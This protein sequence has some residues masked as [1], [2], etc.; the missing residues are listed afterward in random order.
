MSSNLMGIGVSG[1]HA[2]QK[3]LDTTGNNIVNANTEG[4]SRQRTELKTQ[5]PNFQGGNYIG[6]GVTIS[7]I[8]RMHD[9]LATDL[10]REHQ[11]TKSG[12]ESYVALADQVDD[13]L[14]DQ[15]VSLGHSLE[16]YFNKWQNVASDP[17]NLPARQLLITQSKI[18]TEQ[19]HRVFSQ[20]AT[21]DTSINTQMARQVDIVN[22][23]TK[24]IADLNQEISNAK[25]GNTGSLPNDLLD[26]RDS[27]INELA[28]IITVRTLNTD[29]GMTVA[30]GTG[31]SLVVG[32]KNF[33]LETA[34]LPDSENRLGIYL[35]V[36]E[37]S[38]LMNQNVI[39]SYLQ[40][41]TQFREEILTPSINAIGR[42]AVG[43]SEYT[44]QQHQL[45][46]DLNGG[47]GKLF[48][49]NLSTS[50]AYA[51][52]TNY[53]DAQITSQITDISLLPQSDY[54]FEFNGE[55]YLVTRM[56]DQAE[57]GSFPPGTITLAN[58]GLSIT[59]SGSAVSGD[60][61][62][63]Q[64]TRFGARDLKLMP[65]N[66]NDIAA[67]QPVITQR[68][69]Q[70]TGTATIQL[71]EVNNVS[72]G[73]FTTQAGALTP[74]LLIRFTSNSNYDIYDN[75]TPS[76]PVLL[77][78]GNAFIPD[79]LNLMIPGSLNYG[80]QVS[81]EGAPETNDLFYVDYNTGGSTD[82]RNAISI[83]NLQNIRLLNNH[84]AT[85]NSAYGKIVSDV[86]NNTH[87]AHLS[88]EASDSLVKQAQNR[89]QTISGVNLDEEAANLLSFEQAYR[90]AS[91]VVTMANRIFDALMDIME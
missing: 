34:P 32:A 15:N 59:T 79:Q 19:F 90:A 43:V 47:L 35:K 91:R 65:I 6:N 69:D 53:G 30:M 72:G 66:A 62:L 38:M 8:R 45:G 25:T 51:F 58:E 22:S 52:K 23:L 39:G 78:G 1:L 87:Q 4:Y 74:P 64:P 12:F 28:K 89:V 49:S 63:L 9:E 70:N 20:L 75:T 26:Q 11:S 88:L 83:A 33:A 14:A 68:S 50:N 13:L 80:Y 76:S 84:S 57:L 55:H 67:A 21:I 71:S 46:M 48:F 60:Q 37:Q 29:S 61:F 82:N 56:D 10:L 24:S 27:L 77:Q 40:G 41:L 31:E 54:K 42:V 18:M 17:A 2:F 86:G 85:F 3:A 5:I 7:Q 81:M 36:N 44:N 16:E 73:E